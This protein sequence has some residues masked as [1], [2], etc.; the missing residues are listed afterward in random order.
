M[1][2]AEVKAKKYQNKQRQEIEEEMK[3]QN[4]ELMR[5]EY[6]R[7]KRREIQSFR[8]QMEATENMLLMASQGQSMH[9][10]GMMGARRQQHGFGHL[11]NSR[12]QLPAVLN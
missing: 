7:D 5:Q 8:L 3:R 10:L 1:K 12:H 6:F 2:N 4:Q 9:S 11:K